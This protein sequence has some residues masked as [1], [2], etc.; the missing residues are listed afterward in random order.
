MTPC[1][2]AVLAAAGSGPQ[3]LRLTAVGI[4]D[5]LGNPASV[6]VLLD[7]A[8]DSD[9]DLAQAALAALARLPGNEVDADLLARLPAATGKTR[10]VLITLGRAAAH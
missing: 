10:Q 1:M 2:P 6:P 5:R 4:L 8:A 3:K 9:A 7:A